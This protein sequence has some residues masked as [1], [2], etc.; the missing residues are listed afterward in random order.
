MY[1]EDV[2]TTPRLFYFAD[3][4]AFLHKSLYHYTRRKGSILATMDVKKVNDYINSAA[5][6]RNSLE[7]QNAYTDY[8]GSLPFLRLAH[9][10][11]Q[12]LFHHPRASA[13]P[14]LFQAWAAICG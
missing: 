8:R 11:L 5:M 9:R 13:E 7:H 1:F 4:I 6:L 2:A 12:P 10:H 14:F 3:R